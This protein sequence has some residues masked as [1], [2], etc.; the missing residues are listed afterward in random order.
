MGG[1]ISKGTKRKKEKKR[2]EDIQNGHR[3]NYHLGEL[4]SV[5]LGG[6]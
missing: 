6:Q 5:R 4:F 2:R 3:V 1:R